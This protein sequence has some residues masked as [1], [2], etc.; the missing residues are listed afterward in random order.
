MMSW[1]RKLIP[2]REKN[3]LQIRLS[4]SRFWRAL[5]NLSIECNQ[6]IWLLKNSFLRVAIKDG[7][8]FS[9]NAFITGSKSLRN[10]PNTTQSA[11]DSVGLDLMSL[12]IHSAS[13][14]KLRNGLSRITSFV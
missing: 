1:T 9:I 2:A 8:P 7:S 14:S 6:M 13:S 3:D 11:C 10:R 4:C 5:A 12:A